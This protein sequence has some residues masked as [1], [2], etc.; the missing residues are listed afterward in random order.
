[1]LAQRIKPLVVTLALIIMIG[2]AVW[3]ID[4]S[5]MVKWVGATNLNVDFV[6][7]DTVS[8]KPI[9]DARIHIQQSARRT[10]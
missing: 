2:L 1:M 9:P 3:G 5:S 10:A 7:V 4:R 8:E 6:V